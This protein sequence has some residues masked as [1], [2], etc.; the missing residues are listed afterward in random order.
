MSLV[1]YVK[2]GARLAL[3]DAELRLLIA[4]AVRVKNGDTRCLI[5]ER[6]GRGIKVVPLNRAS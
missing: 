1:R 4:E 2:S 6:T 3:T 5:V